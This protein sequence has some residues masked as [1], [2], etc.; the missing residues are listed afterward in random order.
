MDL[1]LDIVVS[2]PLMQGQLTRDLPDA[3]REVFGGATD[4]QRAL[5]FVRS[6][7]AITSVAVG[8]RN[9]AHVRENLGA[10]RSS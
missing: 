3:V 2:A 10:F 6:L 9:T 5:S 8:M 1:G 7:P 4:A